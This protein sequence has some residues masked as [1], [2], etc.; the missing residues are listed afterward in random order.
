MEMKGFELS[1]EYDKLWYLILDGYRI[2]AYILYSDIGEKEIWD[3]VDVKYIFQYERYAIG[4]R[5]IGYE[6]LENTLDEFI[7]N[8]NKYNLHYIKP[9]NEKQ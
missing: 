6:S 8:C 7:K 2:P 4:T 1:T 9:T 5:G 3:I